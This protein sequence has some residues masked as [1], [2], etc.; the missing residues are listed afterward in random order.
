MPRLDNPR[1]ELFAQ[2]IAKGKN[3]R[4]AYIEAGYQSEADNAPEANASRL[5]SCDKVKQRVH[6]LQAQA[7][8]RVE[9]TVESLCAKLETVIERA[10]QSEQNSAAVAAIMGQGKLTGLL[11]DKVKSEVTG[12]DGESLELSGRDLARRIA[13]TLAMG[14]AEKP[15][16]AQLDLEHDAIDAIDRGEHVH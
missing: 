11:V 15:K 16:P 3:Q 10:L 13:M 5:I 1:H 7:A 9:I 2:A 8:K 14:E 12:K 4:E 6:D